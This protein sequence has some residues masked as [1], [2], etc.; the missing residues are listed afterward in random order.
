RRIGK[1][2]QP[3]LLGDGHLSAAFALQFRDH[4]LRDRPKGIFGGSFPG[5]LLDL[6][7]YRGIDAFSE[8][9]LRSISF[10]ARVCQ[11]D[12][13]ISTKRQG[14]LF[15]REPIGEPPQLAVGFWWYE[16]MQPASIRQLSYRR[17][18]FGVPHGDICEPH[19]GIDPLA[20]YD[21]C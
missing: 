11:G 10:G 19:V 4:F 3:S 14:L 5:L 13:R 15:A 17:S 9:P 2:E 20:S 16:Q 21:A 8:E 7:L 12:S 6:A 1:V 18:P